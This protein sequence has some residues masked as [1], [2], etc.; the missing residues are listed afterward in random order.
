MGDNV[1]V[2]ASLVIF[3]AAIFSVGATYGGLSD[4]LLTGFAV[5]S[6]QINVSVGSLVLVNFTT[7]GIN[8]GSGAVTV[9]KASALV[10]SE[11]TVTNG[12]WASVNQGFVIEN[13]GNVNATLNI[14]SGKSPGDFI[15]G[16]SPAYRYSVSN[17][18]S[19]ACVPPAGF[20]MSTFNDITSA[21]ENA[22]I[23]DYF[24]PGSS[25]RVDLELLIPSDSSTGTLS[26]IISVTIAEA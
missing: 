10:N 13:I 3:V 7:D 14:S 11:G 1:L 24:I 9:G 6:G 23:C 22:A 12:T 20:E 15:G 5:D 18:S 2:L 8:W 17:V 21:S 25:I 19:G 26:D 4:A 16:T